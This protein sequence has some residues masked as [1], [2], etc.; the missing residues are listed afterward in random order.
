M[1]THPEYNQNL[2]AVQ[3][4]VQVLPQKVI[5]HVVNQLNKSKKKIEW[6]KL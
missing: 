1:Q 4:C 6:W 5:S 2:D 3:L